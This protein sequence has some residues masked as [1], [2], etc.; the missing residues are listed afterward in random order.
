MATLLIDRIPEELK[1]N[2]KAE[3][4]R[5]G[6]KMRDVILR[7]LELELDDNFSSVL[8]PIKEVDRKK[9]DVV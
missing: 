4:Y 9:A 5:R 2:F 1:N 3:C 7:L 8:K 6:I